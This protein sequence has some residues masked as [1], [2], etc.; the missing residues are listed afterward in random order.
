ME[1]KT[2]K[3]AVLVIAVAVIAAI[4]VIAWLWRSDYIHRYEEYLDRP[5]TAAMKCIEEINGDNEEYP[6]NISLFR[7]MKYRGSKAQEESNELKQI[8]VFNQVL[9]KY[10][11]RD[12][13]ENLV[14]ETLWVLRDYTFQEPERIVGENDQSILYKSQG[15]YVEKRREDPNN[16]TSR[17]ITETH[18][19]DLWLQFNQAADGNWY[20]T[21][22]TYLAPYEWMGNEPL[23]EKNRECGAEFVGRVSEEEIYRLFYMASATQ[24]NDVRWQRGFQSPRELSWEDY[25]YFYF[26]SLDESE[27]AAAYDSENKCYRFT[28]EQIGRRVWEYLGKDENDKN[29]AESGGY[30]HGSI[31]LEDYVVEWGEES[32]YNL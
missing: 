2:N 18:C 13:F 7:Y 28:K 15:Y 14:E 9:E 25:V 31:E 21:K 26:A 1:K 24:L 12:S 16:S 17:L 4:A 6:F 19:E 32:G 20:L 8:Y 27:K 29:A 22:F 23:T 5:E 10:K 3:L 30:P 11:S